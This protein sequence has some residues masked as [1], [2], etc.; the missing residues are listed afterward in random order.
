MS[1]TPLDRS[2]LDRFLKL[3][4]E[5]T[6]EQVAEA[7]DVTGATISR[8]RRG[9]YPSRGLHHSTRGRIETILAQPGWKYVTPISPSEEE[10]RAAAEKA[11][12][13]AG[14]LWALAQDADH[15]A[16]KARDAHAAITSGRPVG[17]PQQR[18]PRTIG[19]GTP[20]TDLPRPQDAK[21]KA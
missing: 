19:K 11:A 8:W 21:K 17:S 13:A 12:Y 16:R 4:R 3:T 18:Q 10:E 5:L 14:V 20:G 7:L 1:I 2:L 6:G 15:I 9:E